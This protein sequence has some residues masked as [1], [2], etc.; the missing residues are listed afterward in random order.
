MCLYVA[1]P[2]VVYPA[3]LTAHPDAL[4][5]TRTLCGLKHSSVKDGHRNMQTFQQPGA[6]TVK[7]N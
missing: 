7:E 4:Q 6:Q 2:Q 5:Y 3:T 1:D